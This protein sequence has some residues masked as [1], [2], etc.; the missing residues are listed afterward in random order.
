MECSLLKVNYSKITTLRGFHSSLLN[1][2]VLFGKWYQTLILW[3]WNGISHLLKVLGGHWLTLGGLHLDPRKENLSDER[4]IANAGSDSE[5]CSLGNRPQT[6]GS[7]PKCATANIHISIISIVKTTVTA[8][9][10]TC[11]SEADEIIYVCKA[12]PDVETS[13][14]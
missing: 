14:A 5:I 1:W 12:F 8:F 2:L 11:F 13:A 7:G 3:L 6:S 4:G 9:A 10:W